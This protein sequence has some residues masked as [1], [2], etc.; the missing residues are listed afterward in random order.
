MTWRG[1]I[2]GW[3]GIGLGRAWY[4]QCWTDALAELL[5]F[6]S[7]SLHV[8]SEVALV[9]VLSITFRSTRAVMGVRVSPELPHIIFHFSLA[10]D[11]FG[12]RTPNPIFPIRDR[13][14]AIP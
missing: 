13:E 2:L 3:L 8:L 5:V 10:C 4:S 6:K 12:A 9:H 14:A 7:L 1:G 11:R